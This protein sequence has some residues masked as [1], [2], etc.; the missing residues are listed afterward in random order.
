MDIQI[1]KL[2]LNEYEE[3]IKK[4]I[5]KRLKN[6]KNRCVYELIES[7]E[8]YVEIWDDEIIP[9]K[10]LISI[11]QHI[12]IDVDKTKELY[13]FIEK[14]KGIDWFM[15]VIDFLKSNKLNFISGNTYNS[16]HNLTHDFQYYIYTDEKVDD[17]DYYNEEEVY[18]IILFHYAGDI[19]SNYC[20]PIV[21]T[22]QPYTIADMIIEMTDVILYDSNNEQ[23]IMQLTT[24]YKDN[25]EIEHEEL[26]KKG[27]TGIF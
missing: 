24:L 15:D 9:H 1:K 17:I 26:I 16:E 3:E 11:F 10:P 27:I 25:E 4:D 6:L 12:E 20:K 18:I 14:N 7:D 21:C 8:K 5:L 22:P 23:Y 2:K 19:R 13:E